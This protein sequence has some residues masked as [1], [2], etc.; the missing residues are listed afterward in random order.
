MILL[1]SHTLTHTHTRTHTHT[2]TELRVLV[3]ENN[4]Y[5]WVIIIKIV[6]CGMVWIIHFVQ[7]LD[8]QRPCQRLC[9]KGMLENTQNTL[10]IG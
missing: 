7:Q 10:D 9:D 3:S 1:F 6:V 2:H 4:S 5:L 8:C